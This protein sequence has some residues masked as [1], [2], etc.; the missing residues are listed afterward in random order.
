M[1]MMYVKEHLLLAV[2]HIHVIFHGKLTNYCVLGTE[3]VFNLFAD[4]FNS[5]DSKQCFVN[6]ICEKA[7]FK[8]FLCPA[9]SHICTVTSNPG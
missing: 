5:L 3:I 7:V 8:L 6:M 9:D 1:K 4:M 2:V